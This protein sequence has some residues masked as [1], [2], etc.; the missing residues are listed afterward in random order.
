MN[1]N[2]TQLTV[3][4][5]AAN[6]VVAELVAQRTMQGATGDNHMDIH[7]WNW[8]SGVGMYGL[9]RLYQRTNNSAYADFLNAWIRHHWKDAASMHTVNHTAPFLTFFELRQ[10]PGNEDYIDACRQ[11]AEWLVTKATRTRDGGFEHTVNA[12]GSH[13]FPE[14]MWADTLFM[15]CIFLAKMGALLNE[16]RYTDEAA[17]QL[18]LHHKIL[19]DKNTGLFYHGWDCLAQNWMSGALWGRA[20]AWITASTV[21]I[22]ELLPDSFEGRDI[23]IASLREQVDALSKYHRVNGHF[24]TLLDDP[25]AYDETSTAAGVSYGV[26]RGI[27]SGYLDAKYKA[28][29]EKAEQAV[30]SKVN[31]SGEVEGV[32]GGT[33]IMPTL[34]DYKTIPTRPALYGQALALL[35]FCED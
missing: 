33:P 14:Q 31:A 21:E 29:A 35:M 5:L 10:L 11:T 20:N 4:N 22:L 18:L 30:I 26:K 12:D 32:S 8:G 17:R 28:M 23:V 24:G 19:K 16:A 3:S 2:S 7:E 1:N 15:A 9:A 27:K 6:Q 25:S 13:L 34:A